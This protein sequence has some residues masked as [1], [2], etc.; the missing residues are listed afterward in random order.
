MKIHCNYSPDHLSSSFLSPPLDPCVRR[1]DIF[2]NILGQSCHSSER[3]NP[4]EVKEKNLAAEVIEKTFVL[5]NLNSYDPFPLLQG[6][7]TISLSDSSNV[8]ASTPP[9]LDLV[10]SLRMKNSRYVPG[11]RKIITVSGYPGMIC[12]LSPSGLSRNAGLTD[13]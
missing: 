3:W 13:A 1:D 11:A 4:G 9:Q 6:T 12:G 2:S 7:T 5:D 8:L 10:T